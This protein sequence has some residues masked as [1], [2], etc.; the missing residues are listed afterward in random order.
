MLTRKILGLSAVVA[1]AL[2]ARAQVVLHSFTGL[3]QNDSLGFALANCGDVDG[4]GVDDLA[5]GA[6]GEGG[7]SVRVWS[8]ASGALR[9]TFLYTANGNQWYGSSVAPAGDLD[10]DGFADLAIGAQGD[11]FSAT[12][13][14]FVEIRSGAN[15]ALLRTLSGPAGSRFGAAVEA[16]GDW[17]GD[18]RL[19]LIVSAQ[20]AD[21]NG[22]NSG[23]VY[24]FDGDPANPTPL[25]ILDGANS[26]DYYGL[27]VAAA[28]DVDGDGV[29]DFMASVIGHTLGSFQRVGRV[30]L[31][32]G[33]NGALLRSVDGP[34]ESFNGFGI[35]LADAGDVNG[36]GRA[37]TL[38][39]AWLYGNQNQG[40]AR[41]F[42]GLDGALLYEQVGAQADEFLG[43]EV[44]ALGDLDDDGIPDFHVSGG[45]DTDTQIVSGGTLATLYVLAGGFQHYVGSGSCALGD[46]N[47]DGLS[48]FAISTPGFQQSRGSVNVYAGVEFEAYSY[49]TSGTTTHGCVPHLSPIGTPSASA[50][51]AFQVSASGLEGEKPGLFFYGLSGALATPWS[52]QGSFLCVKAPVQR[53]R[54]SFPG[55][56]AG[57]C[58]GQLVLDWNAYLQATPVALGQPFQ[59]GDRVWLQGWFRDPPSQKTTS[60][61]DALSF[62]LTP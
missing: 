5:A 38:V 28:G 27:N 54:F 6:P 18:G 39:G 30:D 34:P 16:I 56:V 19:E 7:G 32:S 59:A 17:D 1:A 58:N 60:L 36:D 8:G 23:R 45:G 13:Q 44:G 62:L 11:I 33:A 12:A 26:N 61:T 52:S 15:G 14:P 47:G 42:S 31:F 4:D 51:T 35:A 3:A 22:T 29:A 21:F 53:T 20:N 41:L 55:G 48:D 24:V 40:L 43:Y 49:C 9:H 25:H 50:A 10:G 46:V 57:Q 2:G 37:D